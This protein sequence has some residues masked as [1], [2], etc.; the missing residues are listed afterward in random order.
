MPSVTVFISAENLRRFATGV[1]ICAGMARPDA[2]ISADVLV[3]ADLRGIESHG[4]SRLRMYYDGLIS[5]RHNPRTTFEVVSDQDAAVVVDAHGSMGHPVGVR[6][7]QLAIDKARRY[8]TGAVAVRNSSHFGIAGYYT[9]LAVRAGMVGL[10]FTNARPSV[11]PT[12][13]VRPMLGTN[14]IAFGAPTDEE[15]PFLFD[16]A[17]SIIQRGKIEVMAREG[18]PMPPGYVI[19]REGELLT[20]PRRADAGFAAG[21]NALLP[22]GGAGELLGG[23]KGYGL[24]VM[25]ELLCTALQD[26]AFMGHL[27]AGKGLPA[28]VGH[29]FMA[30][31]IEHFIP[32]ERFKSISGAILREL[33]AAERAPGQSRIYTAGEKEFELEKLRQTSGIPISASLLTELKTLRDE[34]GLGEE[35]LVVTPGEVS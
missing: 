15:C 30:V 27:P 2:E 35:W 17:T 6:A 10:S 19:S 14:P 20:D 29:F 23:H 25:V 24:S 26:N 28:Q 1:F 4:V 11:A 12:F 5:G 21:L 7:M 16:A 31:D 8:G 18:K 34:A 13:S 3:A 9:L 22:L 33:R 32:L